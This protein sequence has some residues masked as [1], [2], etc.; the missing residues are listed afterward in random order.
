MLKNSNRKS[1]AD[2]VQDSL[3]NKPAT[4]AIKDA[5]VW[6]IFGFMLYRIVGY[7]IVLLIIGGMVL[8]GISAHSDNKGTTNT[9]MTPN[10]VY[11]YQMHLGK[12]KYLDNKQ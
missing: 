11:D 12:Y 3:Y 2:I 10:D 6:G 4:T 8:I 5:V 7:I 9:A 1:I